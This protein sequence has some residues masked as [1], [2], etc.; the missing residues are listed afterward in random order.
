LSY[1]V[2]SPVCASADSAAGQR[3]PHL[4]LH[5]AGAAPRLNARGEEY[6]AHASPLLFTPVNMAYWSTSPPLSRAPLRSAENTHRIFSSR[7]TW[8]PAV[9]WE[10]LRSGWGRRLRRQRASPRG[11]CFDRW[12]SENSCDL[13]SVL[14]SAW[15]WFSRLYSALSCV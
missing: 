8:T 6:C 5:G 10:W 1:R 14:L 3:V 12:R 4:F 15:G 9:R 2:F 11:C 13:F 7:C